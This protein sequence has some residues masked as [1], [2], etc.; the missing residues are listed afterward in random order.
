MKIWSKDPKLSF[1]EADGPLSE[2]PFTLEVKHLVRHSVAK[3]R[4][5]EEFFF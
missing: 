3:S 5:G 4:G 2:I 1:K